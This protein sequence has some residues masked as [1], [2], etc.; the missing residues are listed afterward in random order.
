MIFGVAGAVAPPAVAGLRHEAR[1]HAMERHAVVEA[2]ARELLQPRGVVGR[3]VVA[4]LDDDAPLRGVD[5]ERVLRV[6]A[7]R[8]SFGPCARGGVASG[9]AATTASIRIMSTPDQETF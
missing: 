8:K 4:Q 9:S 6:G 2:V 1:D 7:G 3:E 5:Q